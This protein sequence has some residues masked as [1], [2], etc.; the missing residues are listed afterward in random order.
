MDDYNELKNDWKETGSNT[1]IDVVIP[2]YNGERFILQALFSVAQQ[3]YPPDRIIVVDD[4]STDNTPEL[5]RGFK[6]DI[7]VEY[8]R[9]SNGGLSSARNAG[10]SMCIGD[11]IAFLDA[12]DEWYPEKL[13]EQIN[14]F[15]KSDLQNL[16]VVYCGYN[17]IDENGNRTDKYFVLE[18]DPSIRGNVFDRLLEA[19]KIAGSGSGVLV[20]RESFE[21]VGGFDESLRACE[22]WDMWLRLAEYYEFDFASKELVKIRRHHGNMQRDTMHMFANVLMFYEKWLKNP[23]VSDRTFAGWRRKVVDYFTDEFPGEDIV[24]LTRETLSEESRQR[25]FRLTF[26][27]VGLYLLVYMPVIAYSLIIRR[28]TWAYQTV[29]CCIAGQ[30]S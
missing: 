12:D 21:K 23:M 8:V 25:L 30:G 19:N 10:I 13:E 24:R 28:M 15:Q 9:K 20:R 4:G 16:G 26:G 7:P 18:L 27:S 5:V 2:V 3:T 17:I 29:K 1:S 14:V 6:T 22:D 11:F